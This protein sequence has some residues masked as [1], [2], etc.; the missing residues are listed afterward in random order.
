[1]K[2]LF[3][4]VLACVMSL[5][6][7]AENYRCKLAVDVYGEPSDPMEID[8]ECTENANGKY[9]ILLKDFA[10]G[11]M[12]VGDINV[13][14]INAE[15]EDGVTYL[16]FDGTITL[17]GAFA[18]FGA[19]PTTLEGNLSGD[20][21]AIHLQVPD[22]G[23]NVALTN[24]VT[25]IYGS[26]FENWH[27]AGTSDEPNGWHTIKSG[28]GTFASFGKPCAA[29]SD[30]VPGDSKGEKSVKLQSSVVA[31]ISANGTITT[32]RMAVGAMEATSTKNN[33]FVDPSSTD[34]DG[35]NDPF[36]NTF[37]GRPTSITLWYKFKNGGD[38]TNPALI[39]ANLIGEGKFQEPAPE[40]TTYENLI[41]NATSTLEATD[42]WKS[43]TVPFDYAS[44][45]AEDIDPA[46]ILVTINTCS[47][48]GGGSKS[49]DDPDVLYVDDVQL[50][51]APVATSMSIFD[52]EVEGFS[53]DKTEYDITLPEI[54]TD[55]DID[56]ECV[57]GELAAVLIHYEESNNTLVVNMY[58]QELKY[59]KTYTFHVTIDTAVK[60]ITSDAANRTITGRYNANG[61]KVGNNAKGLVITRFADGTAVKSMK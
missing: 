49:N 16:T 3:T 45:N 10:F 27:K 54:P 4:L 61:Q 30:D 24:E 35:N 13:K 31:G 34:V 33:V 41:A 14:D 25:Q 32:G 5:A 7:M 21:L 58:S 12:P 53:A 47:V 36:Y 1:M 48:P 57:N 20:L 19:I 43:V 6:A 37:H 55:D 2:K 39:S 40:G 23:V 60:G 11:G 9:D 18:A 44:Y 15:S 29:I 28:T 38:N 56:F 59:L 52:Q 42:E 26:D 51:Y 8:L 46:S 22:L 17:E 50:N